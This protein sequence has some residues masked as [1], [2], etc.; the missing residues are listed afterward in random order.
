[1]RILHVIQSA[2]QIYGAERCVLDETLAQTR[3]GHHVEALI[4]HETR[5]G[6]EQARLEQELLARGIAT[7][8]V[9]A[10]AQLNPRLVAGWYAPL[11]MNFRSTSTICA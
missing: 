6:D 4:C 7:T 10:L 5:L 9:E 11:R 8:R 3:R 2:S 1:M